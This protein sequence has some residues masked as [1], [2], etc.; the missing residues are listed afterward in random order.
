MSLR[1]SASLNFVSYVAHLSLAQLTVLHY[2]L[3]LLAPCDQALGVRSFLEKETSPSPEECSGCWLYEEANGINS[4]NLV[5]TL[6]CA[7]LA[8]LICKVGRITLLCSP[9]S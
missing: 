3:G 9:R 2:P 8:S 5:C 6:A 4:S 7:I 1:V